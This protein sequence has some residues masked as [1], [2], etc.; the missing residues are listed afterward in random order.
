MPSH[1]VRVVGRQI[2]DP[3]PIAAVFTAR[4]VQ[5]APIAQVQ[6]HMGAALGRA[7]EDQVPGPERV[8]HPGAHGHRLAE[9]L[10]QVGVPGDPDPG[11]GK[12]PLHQPRAVVVGPEAAAPEVGVALLRGRPGKRQHR[13]DA[14]L[15]GGC[16]EQHGS[17]RRSGNGFAQQGGRLQPA[18][19]A[20][21]EQ[22]RP[23]PSTGPGLRRLVHR[24]VASSP[25][26]GGQTVPL[27]AAVPVHGRQ[28]AP[29]RAGL[30][31]VR[32]RHAP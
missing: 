27:R 9:P 7:K 21:L 10:L 22:P 29:D 15:D 8:Q 6:A 17:W 20:I 32:C 2:V 26:L 16:T 13:R 12:S 11:S 25:G 1:R 4:A 19:V 5:I 3:Q 23:Q 28:Q 24:K 31:Q 14:L 18:G 30:Q